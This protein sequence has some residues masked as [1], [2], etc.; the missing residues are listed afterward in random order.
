[1][2]VLFIVRG[3]IYE[4]FHIPSG[5]MMPTL[6]EGDYIGVAKYAYGLRNPFMDGWLIKADGPRRGDVI[7]FSGPKDQGFDFVKRVV[8]L[9]G[10][11]VSMVAGQLFIND[12]AVRMNDIGFKRSAEQDR[13]QAA[14]MEATTVPDYLLPMPYFREHKNYQIKTENLPDAPSHVVLVERWGEALRDFE[15]TVPQEAYFVLGD[16]RHQ[17]VDSR[18]F[19]SVP[20]ASIRGKATRILFS[21]NEDDLPCASP[22]GKEGS[23]S[24]RWYRVGKRVC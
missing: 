4:P 2:L 24:V 22:F 20:R 12:V 19:G 17:S 11:R 1:M 13:C 7:V 15:V 23:K 21:T 3:I 10:E 5:S 18:V 16:N 8:G 6:L 9:P 14:L